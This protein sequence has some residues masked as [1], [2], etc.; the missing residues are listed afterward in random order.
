MFYFF[1]RRTVF[2]ERS[3]FFHRAAQTE[4]SRRR[5]AANGFAFV[6]HTCRVLGRHS[7][8]YRNRAVKF[9]SSLSSQLRGKGTPG[10]TKEE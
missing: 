8:G 3:Q 9:G 4:Q 5:Y 6:P 1:Q 10:S 7:L 2:L